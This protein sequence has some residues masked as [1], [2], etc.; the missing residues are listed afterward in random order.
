MSVAIFH[1]PAETHTTK[2][3]ATNQDDLSYAAWRLKRL[4]LTVLF[5]AE[6]GSYEMQFATK[7]DIYFNAMQLQIDISPTISSYIS[8]IATV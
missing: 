3:G 5:Y 8:I 4:T 7:I 1:A 6:S 2:D